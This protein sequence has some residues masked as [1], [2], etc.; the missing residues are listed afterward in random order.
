MRMFDSATQCQ[1]VTLLL[2]GLFLQLQG[3]SDEDNGILQGY[4]EGDY[5]YLAAPQ[6]GYLQSLNSVRGSRVTTG[7][8][9][10]VVNDSPDVVDFRVFGRRIPCRIG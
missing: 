6:A 2:A 7:Q 3:C 9:V 1:L 10:F 4:V 5:L 8:I